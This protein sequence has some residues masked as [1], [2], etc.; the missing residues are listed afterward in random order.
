MANQI[1]YWTLAFFVIAS[2]ER[3]AKSLYMTRGEKEIRQTP[4][5]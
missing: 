4:V 3:F 5:I 2:V 1:I